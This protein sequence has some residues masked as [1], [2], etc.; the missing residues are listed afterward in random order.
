[1]KVL[2]LHEMSGVHTELRAGLR[3]LG[4][5]AQIA[6]FGDGFKR[7]PTDI[8][9]G[10]VGSGPR[11]VAS[12][13]IKQL[14]LASN[15]RKYD[16]IQTISP[17]PFFSPMSSLLESLVLGG[18][19]RIVYV[20]AGSDAIYRK[21]VRGLNYHPPH[22]WYANATELSRLHRLLGRVD[23]IVPVCWEYMEFIRQEGIQTRD[24]MPFPIDISKQRYTG[25]RRTGKLKVFHPLNRT[26]LNFDFKGTL[27]IQEAFDRLSKTHGHLAE[28]ICAGGMDHASY[29]AM[30][31]EIDVLVDQAYSYSYGM[32]AAYGM[33][34]G[35]VVLSGMERETRQHAFY[36]ECPV[37]NLPP[38]VDGI[39]LSVSKI[40]E[41][42]NRAISIGEMSR[43][44]AED[45]HGHLKVASKYLN[46]YEQRT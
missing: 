2:L 28:F 41:D 3:T 12:K 37:L 29:D 7:Y 40:I 11:G 9:L 10:I 44:F 45:W 24:V 19:S 18:R 39:I 20:A 36:R 33:A 26:N 21:Y 1:M 30:T 31:D 25:I 16:V 32:S 34:K 42:R 23:D 6:T 15:A 14:Q 35:K 13:V 46:I 22:D 5:D 8:S 43:Q 4:V 27:L 38:S 17:N